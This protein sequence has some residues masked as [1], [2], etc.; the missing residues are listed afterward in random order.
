MKKNILEL[1]SA[2]SICM[3][4]ISCSQGLEEKVSSLEAEKSKLAE[5]SS[6]LNSQLVKAKEENK[7]LKDQV[8]Q[9]TSQLSEIKN[10]FQGV[11]QSLEEAQDELRKS[12]LEVAKL[13]GKWEAQ[14][15]EKQRAAKEAAN[16][17]S[18][19]VQLGVVMRS[20]D[21]TPVK[22]AKVYLTEESFHSI[23]GATAAVTLYGKNAPDKVFVVPTEAVWE[24]FSDAGISDT[25]THSSR[26]D[27]AI[28]SKAK[29]VSSTDFLG[30]VEFGDL[31]IGDYYLICR[32]GIGGGSG[33]VWSK[34]IQLKSGKNIFSFNQSDALH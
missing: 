19:I 17:A 9:L 24:E 11:E 10:R 34:K 30:K 23:A 3:L 12:E 13:Q 14:E 1:L 26:I 5:S 21:T 32:T 6:E 28:R 27:S 20:G 15:Q 16:K 2:L 22:S 18:L 25:G 31:P 29:F 33:V 7:T 8:Q 4:V